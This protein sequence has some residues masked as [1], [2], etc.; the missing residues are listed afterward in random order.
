MPPGVSGVMLGDV[1]KVELDIQLV[2]PD[3]TA[4]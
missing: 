1:V 3:T 2:E 4:L